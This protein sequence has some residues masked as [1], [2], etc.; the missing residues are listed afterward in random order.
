MP[1]VVDKVTTLMKFVTVIK[2]ILNEEPE[3]FER[4]KDLKYAYHFKIV[5]DSGSDVTRFTLGVKNG[6]ISI[7][8]QYK[9]DVVITMYEGAFFDIIFGRQTVEEAYFAGECDL[10]ARE[11][12]WTMHLAW[13]KESL[14]A[15]EKAI[16][17]KIDQ[18]IGN[19]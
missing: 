9:P 12:N 14:D 13:I 1:P 5:D 6:K 16:R 19:G 18:R 8:P 15:M 4:N 7:A 3:F 11:G 10:W 2:D 17:V